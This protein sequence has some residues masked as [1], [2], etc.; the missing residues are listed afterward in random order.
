MYIIPEGKKYVSMDV[1]LIQRL[2]GAKTALDLLAY[3]CSIADSE[4][5]AVL[6]AGKVPGMSKNAVMYAKQVLK[7]H[8]VIISERKWIGPNQVALIILSPECVRVE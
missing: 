4:G 7:K 1:S 8:D 3:I 2:S 6:S 5:R